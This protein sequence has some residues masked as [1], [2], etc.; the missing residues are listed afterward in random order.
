MINANRYR[1]RGLPLITIV[2]VSLLIISWQPY[3][4]AQ[5]REVLPDLGT[6]W[7]LK[8]ISNG[9][10]GEGAS[11]GFSWINDVAISSDGIHLYVLDAEVKRVSILDPENGDVISYFG[12]KGAG[13]GELDYPRGV[14]CTN[15]G[16]WIFD[17]PLNRLT[18]FSPSGQY[19]DSITPR[20][21]ALSGFTVIDVRQNRALLHRSF[22][23]QDG[24]IGVSLLLGDLEG[25]TNPLLTAES[26][27]EVAPGTAIGFHGLLSTRAVALTESLW[28]VA[29]EDPPLIYTVE[30]GETFN[31]QLLVNLQTAIGNCPPAV[32]TARQGAPQ[33]YISSIWMNSESTHLFVH[34]ARSKV[35]KRPNETL[36]I[37]PA[38]I[39]DLLIGIKYPAGEVAE[40]MSIEVG[41]WKIVAFLPPDLLYLAGTKEDEPVLA[42]YER[43][44]GSQKSKFN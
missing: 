25:E 16:V 19:L 3:I 22:T 31:I 2:I 17:P 39:G 42:R 14:I 27:K 9:T 24:P 4:S 37:D 18:Q 6:E 5:S 29:I 43:V 13:P 36:D 15:D 21:M 26:I 30:L 41:S 8:W 40:T 44:I 1:L 35:T 34:I 23:R 11:F 20:D 7:Q 28:I 10:T 12:R 33:C 32:E 38:G